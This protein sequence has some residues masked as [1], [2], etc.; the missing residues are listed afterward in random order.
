MREIGLHRVTPLAVEI[1][2]TLIQCLNVDVVIGF[3]LTCA[4]ALL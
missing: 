4:T 1:E 3:P 2:A